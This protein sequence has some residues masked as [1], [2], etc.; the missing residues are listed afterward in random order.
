M[1]EELKVGQRIELFEIL[2]VYNGYSGEA[3]T[4][5]QVKPGVLSE[6]LAY[7]RCNNT[8]DILPMFLVAS[9]NYNRECRRV[10]AVT[11]KSLKPKKNA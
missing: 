6:N 2:P 11:I 4:P 5:G 1:E 7:I 8:G 9:D 3:F 10:G